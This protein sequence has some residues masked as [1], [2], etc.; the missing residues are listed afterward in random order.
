MANDKQYYEQWVTQGA[1][2]IEALASDLQT[3]CLWFIGEQAAN[4][5]N[6]WAH[7]QYVDFA[8]HFKDQY[9]LTLPETVKGWQAMLEVFCEYCYVAIEPVCLAMYCFDYKWS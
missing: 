7:E 2:Q 4:T 8:A 9:G 6:D 5:S 3:A 1:G